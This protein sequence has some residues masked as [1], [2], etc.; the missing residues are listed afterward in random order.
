[1]RLSFFIIC[2]ISSLFAFSQYNNE[3][4]FGYQNYNVGIQYQR[5]FKYFTGRLGVTAYNSRLY[6]TSYNRRIIS[7]NSSNIYFLGTDLRGF[8][9]NLGFQHEI[10]KR[11]ITPIIY[12]DVLYARSG[13]RIKPIQWGICGNIADGYA[14]LFGYDR[15]AM[16]GVNA[17]LGLRL[18]IS[19]RVSLQSALGITAFTMQ[20]KYEDER[21][22]ASGMYMQFPNQLS[23]GYKF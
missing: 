20:L 2:L 17:G 16:L 1:M 8:N 3:V 19:K 14:E 22:S 18:K 12:T 23:I 10:G 5:D 15:S 6:L 21:R 7:Q 11:N 9:L 4:Q 13:P